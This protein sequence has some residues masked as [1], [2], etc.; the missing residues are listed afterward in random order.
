MRQA[1]E[2]RRAIQELEARKQAMLAIMLPQSGN[3]E[4]KLPVD[5]LPSFDE[6]EVTRGRLPV[7]AQAEVTG[8][9]LPLNKVTR[10]GLPPLI[11]DEQLLE[12][13]T[14]RE[15]SIRQIARELGVSH[16]ALLKRLKRL[17]AKPTG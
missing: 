7:T 15:K 6:Y 17:Q 5:R 8:E 14:K 11:T 3:V 2:L 9:R 12:L 1:E 16:V 10:A 4:T 13:V